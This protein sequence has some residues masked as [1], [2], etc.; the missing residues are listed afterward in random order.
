MERNF[1]LTCHLAILVVETNILINRSAN[2]T[3]TSFTTPTQK[4]Q[5]PQIRFPC[6][7][8]FK[9]LNIQIWLEKVSFFPTVKVSEIIFHSLM[10][11]DFRKCYCFSFSFWFMSAKK[12]FI[13]SQI[14]SGHSCLLLLGL[15]RGEHA[16]FT[17]V[18][19]IGQT[20][21]WVNNAN[22]APSPSNKRGADQQ[23]RIKI[24]VV[25]RCVLTPCAL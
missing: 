19:I 24:E 6:L 20:K 4:R 13:R 16:P 14:I 17:R 9:S 10:N 1:Y 12:N 7:Y 5:V 8:A 2:D 3:S 23:E 11:L 22:D 18:F 25:K 21:Q 15:V